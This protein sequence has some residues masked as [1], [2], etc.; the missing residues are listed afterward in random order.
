M[1]ANLSF[2]W[3][4]SLCSRDS[5]YPKLKRVENAAIGSKFDRGF[6]FFKPTLFLKAYEN[7]DLSI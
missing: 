6:F 3:M 2:I 1:W 4:G 5:N 7:A